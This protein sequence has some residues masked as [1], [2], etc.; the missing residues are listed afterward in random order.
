MNFGLSAEQELLRDTF[1]R[2]FAAESDPGRV[3]AAEPSGFDAALWK[4][5]AEVDAIGLRVSVSEGGSG[6]GLLE[7]VLVAEQAGRALASGPLLEAI[8]A[9]ALLAQFD[10]PPARELVGRALD[11]SAMVTLAVRA[12]SSGEAQLVPGGAVADAVVGLDGDE[13]VLATRGTYTSPTLANLGATPVAWWTLSSP[14]GNGTRTVLA[15]GEA[16]RE[17]FTTALDEWR[18]LSASA[19]Y[20]LGRRAIEIAS[21]YATGR[22][23]FDRPIGAFQGIAHPLADAVTDVEGARLLTW[24]AVWSIASSSAHA[25]SLIP[26]AFGWASRAATRAVACSLHTHGGY[27]LSLEYDIQLYHRR[28]KA[29]A[30][31]AGDPRDAFVLGAERRWGGEDGTDITLPDAGEPHIDFG[32]GDAEAVRPVVRRFFDEHLTPEVRARMH[33][34]WEGH[35]WTIQR[36]LADAGLLFPSWPKEYGGHDRDPWE[37]AVISE[38][39]EHAGYGRHAITTTFMVAEMVRRF[40]SDDLKQEVLPRIARGDAICSLGYTE[41]QSGSDVAAAQ[42]RAVRDGRD[43][44]INGHKM[45]TSGADLAQYV[46]L[47]TRTDA[48]VAKHKGLTMFLVPLDTPG[49]EIQ[50]VHTMS[51]ERTNATFYE[52]VRVDDRYRVGDVDDGWSVLHSALDLEHGGGTSAA[53]A[54]HH[55]LVEAA[56]GWARAAGRWSDPRVRERLGFVATRAAI[57]RALGLE[58]SWRGVHGVPDQGAGAMRKL[59]SAEAW[60]ED[61]ADLMDLCAP[62]SVLGAGAH[63]AVGD[64]AVELDYRRSASLSV[65]GGSSE[66]MRSIIAQLTL[67]LPR[68]RS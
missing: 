31:I 22:I 23:Q 28:A 12:V 3:R 2:L 59:F 30:T 56:A 66:I 20:G 24:L 32:Y 50:P 9:A 43:W 37:M 5:L 46:F 45:F 38:E 68:S 67:G 4:R 48:T 62:D 41:P 29:W 44:V 52:H 17:A 60:I 16:A 8:V 55:H 63:G 36:A 13:L 35:D 65:Y 25:A 53:G 27:G 26:F 42:T 1:A 61:A 14:P 47:L 33:F 39:F 15:R 34:S 19:L 21:E 40:G 64:G 11:G 7:A 18:L 51:D 58:A 10:P 57:A 49:I 54:E 6:A